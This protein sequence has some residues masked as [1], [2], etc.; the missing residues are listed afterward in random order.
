[1]LHIFKQSALLWTTSLAW[2]AICTRIHK[3]KYMPSS[4]LYTSNIRSTYPQQTFF[5][6]HSSS[7]QFFMPSSHHLCDSTHVPQTSD[8]HYLHLFFTAPSFQISAPY[9][10]T[11][12]TTHTN[13]LF[14]LFIQ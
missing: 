1:M 6:T 9:S 14:F 7:S 12:T 2:K 8:L 13:N 3:Y 5:L 10:T 11:G 4:W